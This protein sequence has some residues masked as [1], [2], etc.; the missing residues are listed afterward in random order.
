[1]KLLTTFKVLPLHEVISTVVSWLYVMV[2]VFLSFSCRDFLLLSPDPQGFR[3]LSRSLSSSPLCMLSKALP[4]STNVM[5]VFRLWLFTPSMRRRSARMWAVVDR[6]GR[7]PFWFGLRC[8]VNFWLYAVEY[9]HVGQFG[10]NNCEHDTPVV[11]V[12]T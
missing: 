1:M 2:F 11:T 5:M 8:F 10:S 9:H 12:L 3:M 6:P 4:K 7:N